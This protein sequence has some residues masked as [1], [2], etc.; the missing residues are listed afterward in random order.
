MTRPT[1]PRSPAALVLLLI[2]FTA[3]GLPLVG[4]KQGNGARTIDLTGEYQ[5]AA[6][7]LVT[8]R[9]MDADGSFRFDSGETAELTELRDELAHTA[10]RACAELEDQRPT[11]IVAELRARARLRV[12]QTLAELRAAYVDELLE[13]EGAGA[14]LPPGAIGSGPCADRLA[15][16]LD[17]RFADLRGLAPRLV[18]ELD[19]AGVELPPD[20]RWL[21]VHLPAQ[22]RA[23]HAHLRLRAAG[24]EPDKETVRDVA[25]EMALGGAEI[26]RAAGEPG[27]RTFCDTILQRRRLLDNAAAVV[28]RHGAHRDDAGR[29]LRRTA[30]AAAM[31]TLVPAIERFNALLDAG[32]GVAADCPEL[33]AGV[34]PVRR[35]WLPD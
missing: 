30:A 27:S 17:R 2:T 24:E 21:L 10:V 35:F 13:I 15:A 12:V 11:D 22:L 9:L 1:P 14:G 20:D 6:D 5:S 29:V 31:P 34:R 32:G 18:E 19:R 33:G 7:R 4:C 8:L 26:A 28:T 25:E 16:L 3:A 23:D